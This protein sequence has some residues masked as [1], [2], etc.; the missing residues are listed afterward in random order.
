MM[1]PTGS[2]RIFLAAQPV[3]FRKGMD[4]LAGHVAN[5]FDLDP[6]CGAIF[7]FRSRSAAKIKVLVW[8]GTG[9]V[10][11]MKRLAEGRF[12]WPKIQNTPVSLS[13]VQF[14]ALFEGSDWTRIGTV[15]TLRPKFL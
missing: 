1:V 4:G 15:Q 12:S 5:H 6:Y 13:R 8:D 11:V 10:L 3:D 14:D 2:F 9:M 7:V